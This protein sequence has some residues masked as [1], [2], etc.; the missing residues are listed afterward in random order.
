MWSVITVAKG[1]WPVT[2]NFL[3]SLYETADEEIDLIYVENGSPDYVAWN[4]VCRWGMDHRQPRQPMK[5]YRFDKSVCLAAAWNTAV[6]MAVGN[7][8]L[9]CN[10][11][12]VFHRHGWLQAFGSS[13]DD[14]SVGIVGMTGMSW[15]DVPFIQGSIFAFEREMFYVGD[16]VGFDTRFEFTCEEVDFNLRVQLAGKKIVQLPY[17]RDEGYIEHLEGATRN[18]YKS[19]TTNYQRLAHR[20]RLEF[21]YKWQNHLA[22]LGDSSIKIDD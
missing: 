7:R 9:I 19:E 22:S 6:T 20:S 16:E 12:I 11:D 14:K 4:E 8:I 3:D 2:K 5:M 10:N 21:C 17:L 1:M 13:L 18:F 15:H